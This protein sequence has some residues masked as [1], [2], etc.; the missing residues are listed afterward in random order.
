MD[1]KNI[2]KMPDITWWDLYEN[3]ELGSKKHIAS[4]IASIMIQELQEQNITIEIWCND[5]IEEFQDINV[6]FRLLDVILLG[7]EYSTSLVRNVIKSY[8]DS[9]LKVNDACKGKEN[10]RFELTH[11]QNQLA[12]YNGYIKYINDFKMQKEESH[13]R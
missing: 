3:E 10:I 1:M 5:L 12:K 4:H 2:G 9:L 13:V 8:E 6:A 7:L 11:C